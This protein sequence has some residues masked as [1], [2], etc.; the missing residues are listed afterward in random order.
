MGEVQLAVRFSYT[1]YVNMRSKYAQPLFPKMHYSHPLSIRQQDFLRFRTI[2]I[3]STR[4]G[5]AEPPLKKEVV[6]YML[7]VGSHIWSLR[8][9]KANFFRLMCVV[10][11]IMT[12]GKWFDQRM[13]SIN[14]PLARPLNTERRIRL[15]KQL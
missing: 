8:R 14:K 15:P 9:A 4:L 10:S 5:R 13:T 2:Q 6:D 11:P 12:I 1:S 3:L 7:D